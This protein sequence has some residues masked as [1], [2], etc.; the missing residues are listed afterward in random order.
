MLHM[1][2]AHL[3][4]PEFDNKMG[5]LNSDIEDR[6]D[7]FVEYIPGLDVHENEFHD[8]N[9]LN[10]DLKDQLDHKIAPVYSNKSTSKNNVKSSDSIYRQKDEQ[11]L[12]DQGSNSESSLNN[13][14]S[15]QNEP[16]I[17]SNSVG[18]FSNE[19]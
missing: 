5:Q 1:N 15:F 19:G 4:E 18:H 6:L 10:S 9:F 17:I 13:E 14:P 3:D 2:I 12:K 8:K 16:A 11:S 7:G